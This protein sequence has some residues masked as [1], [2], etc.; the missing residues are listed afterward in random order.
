MVCASMR[1]V[2]LVDS[3]SSGRRGSVRRYKNLVFV[4]R[5]CNVLIKRFDIIFNSI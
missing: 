3:H 2:F 1:G 5:G 4:S